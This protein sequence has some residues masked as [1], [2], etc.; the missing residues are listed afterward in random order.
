MAN[1]KTP[2]DLDA[3]ATRIGAQ[4]LPWTTGL[5]SIS[6]HRDTAVN[7]FRGKIG[8]R[9]SE[10]ASVG[11]LILGDR[12]AIAGLEAVITGKIEEFKQV[13]I[14]DKDA[15]NKAAESLS[16]NKSGLESF[17]STLARIGILLPLGI[18]SKYGLLLTADS[19]PVEK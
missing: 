2:G 6:I 18:L 10:M 1:I 14:A 9:V 3:L 5:D 13:L 19:K 8:Q 11:Q 17:F 12:G 16:D 7:D 15:L 4:P